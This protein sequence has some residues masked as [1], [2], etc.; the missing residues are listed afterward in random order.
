MR[1]RVER[2]IQA[3]NWQA[4][5]SAANPKIGSLPPASAAEIRRAADDLRARL[6]AWES[7]EKGQGQRQ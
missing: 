4:D 6:Q 2:A 7:T 1:E 3:L 5:V